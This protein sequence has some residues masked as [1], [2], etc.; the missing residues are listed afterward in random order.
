MWYQPMFIVCPL[1]LTG[2]QLTIATSPEQP[3]IIIRLIILTPVLIP[4]MK[5]SL[6][7]IKYFL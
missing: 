2:Y 6:R 5:I 4:M 3:K 7:S 1:K